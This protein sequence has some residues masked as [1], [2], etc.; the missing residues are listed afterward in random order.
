MPVGTDEF[1]VM[2][3]KNAYAANGARSCTW[4]QQRRMVSQTGLTLRAGRAYTGRVVIAGNPGARVDVSPVWALS[5]RIRQ[6]TPIGVG[7]IRAGRRYRA[8]NVP[9]NG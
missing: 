5:S 3:R 9:A 8:F 2:D 1:V 7:R 6:R 4:R